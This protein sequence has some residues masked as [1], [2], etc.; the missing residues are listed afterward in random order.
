MSEQIQW[1]ADLPTAEAEAKKVGKPVLLELFMQGCGH[2]AKLHSE[3]HTD[4]QVIAAL[5]EGYLPVKLDG[6]ANMD[7]VQRFGVKGAPT[8][9]ILSPE[10]QELTRFAGYR[11]VEDYLQKLTAR[12]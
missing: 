11:D 10:G 2:C 4:A 7:I 12:S 3:A 6:M 8:T 1:Y 5:N 9:I